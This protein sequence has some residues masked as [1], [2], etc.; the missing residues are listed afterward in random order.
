MLKL[1]SRVD[2]AVKRKNVLKEPCLYRVILLN[3]EY[4]TMDFVIDIIMLVFHRSEEEAT[5]I[6]QD[7]HKNGRGL[8][9]VYAEDVARTKAAQV[10]AL[11]RSKQFPL[12]CLVEPDV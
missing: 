5:A 9:G 10:G 2:R 11:A 12:A 7:I 8:V 1:K 6:M 4:T 3:D